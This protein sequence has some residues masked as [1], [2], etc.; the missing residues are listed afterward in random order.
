MNTHQIEEILSTLMPNNFIGVFAQDKIPNIDA[1]FHFP[2]SFVSNT[3]PSTKPGEHWVAFYYTSPDTLEFFDS[4]GLHPS[5][6]GFIQ[7]PSSINHTTLQSLDSNVC[8]QYCIYF[9][10]HRSRG[11]TMSQ[12]I[13]TFIKDQAWNDNSVARFVAKHFQSRRCRCSANCCQ[14]CI[15]RKLCNK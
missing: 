7:S 10:Y 5:I 14:S 8:G 9:L 1:S 6:Y 13:G 3:H 11:K 4:Y 12:I 15:K 2:L